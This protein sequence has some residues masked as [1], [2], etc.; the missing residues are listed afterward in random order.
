MRLKRLELFGF[1]SFADRTVLEFPHALTGV[2]GPNGCGKSNVVD[3]IRWALGETRPTSMR[4]AEMTDVIFK[5]STSRPALGVAEVTLVLDNECGT[6]PTHGA[7][8]AVTR[9]VFRTGEGE[10]EIDGAKVRLKDVRDVLFDTG[11]GSRG[12]SVLEQGKIDAVLSANPQD[13]RAIFEEAAGVSRFRQRRKE[14]ES[15]LKRVDQDLERIDDL[16]GELESRVRSLKVQAGRARTWIEV[17]DAWREKGVCLAQNQLVRF[18]E[19]LS[20]AV[21]DLESLDGRVADL[22]ARREEAETQVRA[23]DE[24]QRGRAAAVDAANAELSRLS[25]ELLTL[26]ERARQ[27]AER[28]ASWEES[29]DEEERRVEDLRRRLGE[30]SAELESTRADRE[31]LAIEAE[32]AEASLEQLGGTFREAAR[33]YRE[34]REQSEEQSKRVNALIHDKAAAFNAARQLEQSL[35]PLSERAERAESRLAELRERVGAARSEWAAAEQASETGEQAVERAEEERV[36]R[37]RE[38]TAVQGEERE[39]REQ[40]RLVD[41]ERAALR[42]RIEAL[43]DWEQEREGLDA[44]ARALLEG[45]FAAAPE[46]LGGLLVDRLRTRPEF[47]R[48]LDAALGR[49]AEAIVLDD[50]ALAVLIG[51]WLKAGEIGQARLVVP[52]GL[53]RGACESAIPEVSEGLRSELRGLLLEH[54]EVEP[55]LVPLAHLMLCDCIL[56]SSLPAALEL[57]RELPGWRLVTPD[58]DLVDS[59]GVLTGHREVGQGAVGRRAQA[60]ELTERE[61]ELE[62]ALEEATRR[63]AELAG[64]RERAEAA[65][66]A[67]AAELDRARAA[68]AEALAARRAAEGRVGDAERALE[69]G[70]SESAGLIDE[71]DRS[72]SRLAELQREHAEIE[73]AFE[74]ENSRLEELERTRHEIESERDAAGREE[75][76]ARIELTRVREQSQGLE[77]RLGDLVRSTQELEGEIQRAVGL[78]A[79]N[80]ERAQRGGDER[81]GI[82]S[83]KSDLGG[84]RSAAAQALD[85]RRDEEREGRARIEALRVEADAATG[86]LE[87]VMADRGR[88][89]L[90]QQRSELARGEVLRRS[91]EDFQLD[92]EALVRLFDPEQ[93]RLEPEVREVLEQEV[94]EL[95]KKLDR[96]GPVNLE[97]V[98]ELEEV[99][100]RLAFMTE[101]RADLVDSKAQLTRTL[102][103]INEE[104][105]RL[106]L[107]AFEEIREHFKAIFRQLFGGGRADITLAEGEP[108][109][110]AGIEI[111]A[112]P[113][114]RESLPIGLLSGGQRTMT[115]LALLFAVFKSRPS[116]F[117]VLDEVDAAL[118]DANV[119]RFLGMLDGFLSGSQFVVVTHNKGTMNACDMLYGITMETKG[120]SR[121]V[122]VE[123]SEVDG[124]V[125]EA[126]GNVEAAVEARRE[127]ADGVAVL[128]E[129]EEGDEP[130]VELVPQ[131]Q[132]GGVDPAVESPALPVDAS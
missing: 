101:Q 16:V 77:R 41:V 37:G 14:T 52:A 106:F 29:A 122:S 112:R 80:R 43:L 22:R 65:L 124:F 104:S 6:I 53:N 1:K 4:G 67:A 82:E 81:D 42:S 40:E 76:R 123:L 54:V 121:N 62:R 107:E 75:Q 111:T 74:L 97:A 96:L 109:L 84:Q 39:A 61:A 33:R 9:R 90:D 66:E 24:E 30:R 85:A 32:R 59:T 48:A 118:D 110:E 19:E 69:V 115:A 56:V 2:V 58:G 64:R 15:R 26:E 11:L 91:E 95:K 119:G 13:R 108:V 103:T 99:G 78:V 57:T 127:V 7:E 28:V 129:G 87:G 18:D 44:G 36:E 113:P 130:I 73:R 35:G 50:P 68:L 60:A 31:R 12:Y 125:P 72:R 132:R 86:E 20:A 92:H 27:L 131:A 83:R 55:A 116:P 98:E 79:E 49:A 25:G 63:R 23:R 8:V 102:A 93:D 3:A 70:T 126:T 38:L 88:R 71:R 100:Q 94:A 89:Q 10:Y 47:A 120:V 5:G 51:D 128:E 117:C 105:E 45:E 46:A 21:A 17:R 114:G 34:A